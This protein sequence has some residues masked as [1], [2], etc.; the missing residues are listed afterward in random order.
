MLTGGPEGVAGICSLSQDRVVQAL[1]GGG[2]SITA[3]AWA[4]SQAIISTSEGRVKCFDGNADVANFAVHHGDASDIAVHPCGDVIA[5]VGVDKSYVLYDLETKSVLTQ[6]YSNSGMFILTL[7]CKHD[8]DILQHFL[9]SSSTQMVISWP[10]AVKTAK[11]R[12]STSDLEHKPQPSTLAA[13]SRCSTSPRT[14]LGL[15]LYARTPQ[16]YRYG[17]YESRPRFEVWT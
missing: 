11:S 1:K 9:A 2:G 15:L 16:R 4:G 7:I 13:Q 5:S 8:T 10:Q 6:V 12:F 17:I 14:E 3:G